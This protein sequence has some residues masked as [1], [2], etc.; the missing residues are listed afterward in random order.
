MIRI[1]I[2]SSL[3]LLL[4]VFLTIAASTASDTQVFTGEVMDVQCAMLR[5]HDMMKQQE[6]AKDAEEC[7]QACL[8][9]GGKLVLYDPASQKVYQLDE[10]QKFMQYAGL[11]VKVTGSYNDS[12]RTIHVENVERVT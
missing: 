8:R 12:D 10:Q 2:S 4:A 7:T 9:K 3:G 11:R 1:T 6:G 5:S